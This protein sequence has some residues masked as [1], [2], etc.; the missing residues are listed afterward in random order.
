MMHMHA[1]FVGP[2]GRHR[3]DLQTI[4]PCLRIVLCVYNVQENREAR[5]MCNVLCNPFLACKKH[6]MTDIH[7]QLYEV[8]GE[9]ITSDSMV[10]R[11]VRHFNDGRENVHDDPRS[12]WLSVVNEDLAGA[13]E[14]KIQANRLFTILSLSLHF[15]QI[16]QSLLHKIVSDKLRF[17]KLCS[18][19]VPKLLMEN[20]KKWNGRPAVW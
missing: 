3:H 15:P 1:E 9:H 14:E 13:V 19:W 4:K 7:R 10:R 12:D 2:L 6:D 11:W 8:Y 5:R 16:S 18:R 17:L 20:T